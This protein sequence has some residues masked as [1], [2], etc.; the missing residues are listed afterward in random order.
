MT[1]EELEA[2]KAKLAE[3]EA[4]ETQLRDKSHETTAAARK[5]NDLNRTLIDQLKS[6]KKEK[7]KL[8]HDIRHAE[9]EINRKKREGENA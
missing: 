5:L 6:V 2:A 3:L 8:A 4:Q 7:D 1:P 9:N